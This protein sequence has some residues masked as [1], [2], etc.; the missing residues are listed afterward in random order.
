MAWTA[1]RVETIER[2]HPDAKRLTELSLALVIPWRDHS[3]FGSR[4]WPQCWM[5][6]QNEQQRMREI[7][8]A[9]ENEILPW[10]G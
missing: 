6:E 4:G 10:L 3:Q 7:L 2:V 1:T 8:D 9:T 5:N